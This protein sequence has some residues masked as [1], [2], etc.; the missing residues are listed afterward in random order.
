MSYVLSLASPFVVEW[1]FVYIAR[2][3]LKEMMLQTHRRLDIRNWITAGTGAG[4]MLSHFQ[5][6]NLNSEM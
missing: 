2:Y 3:V 4:N 6:Q 1:T 5:I